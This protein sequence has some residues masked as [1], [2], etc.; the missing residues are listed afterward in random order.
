MESSKCRKC[1]DKPHFVEH[2]DKWY[3]FS[4]NTYQDEVP[5]EKAAEMPAVVEQPIVEEPK[6]SSP[7]VE[8]A[9]PSPIAAEIEEIEKEEAKPA[10]DKCGAALQE[11]DDGSMFCPM[12]TS[13]AVQ[14]VDAASAESS[15]APSIIDIAIAEQLQTPV[16]AEPQPAPVEAA[17]KAAPEPKPE[18]AE[19]KVRMCPNCGQPLKFIEKYSRYYCYSCK[20]YAPKESVETPKA[21]P[22]AAKGPEAKKCPDCGADMK[23]IEKYSE[24]YCYPCKKYPLKQKKV[25]E[26]KAAEKPAEKPAV[27]PVAQP[28]KACDPPMCPK[29]GKPLKH[30]EK[31]DRH[32][33]YEC[34]QY[35]PKGAGSAEAAKQEKKVCPVC[36]GEMAYIQQYN[37]WYCYKCK[38][39]TLRPSKPMLLI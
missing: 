26:K 5:E 3:C 14:A 37:E 27:A 21:E 6:E 36:N 34:K 30:V 8:E 7:A 33:C 28:A 16:H 11:K 32:Y 17:P 25:P 2:I 35:A 9:K 18:A 39:Y 24:W 20:K 12:C 29:C 13:S 19:V 23:Y 4:C 31:Y 1:G 22:A 10:C 38:K 15:N